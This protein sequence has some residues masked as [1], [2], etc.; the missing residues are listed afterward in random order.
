MLEHLLLRFLCRSGSDKQ[1]EVLPASGRYDLAIKQLICRG[2]AQALW[3][4]VFLL[5]FL[6]FWKGFG[7]PEELSA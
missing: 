7:V 6:Y 1:A 5:E 2:L 3:E 4:A